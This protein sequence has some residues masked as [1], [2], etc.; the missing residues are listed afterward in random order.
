MT[1]TLCM[2]V[3]NHEDLLVR[4]WRSCQKH[5]PIDNAILSVS[6][7]AMED[8][9]VD[10]LLSKCTRSKLRNEVTILP[11]IQD[12][13]FIG[14]ARFAQ[15]DEACLD[16]S[17]GWIINMDD[18]DHVIYD[19][20]LNTI[21][22]HVGLWHAG[23]I[24]HCIEATSGRL[25]GDVF[26]RTT[27]AVTS[28]EEANYFRGAL[29]GIRKSVWRQIQH[30]VCR[31][32]PSDDWGMAY[33]AV[34][35]GTGVHFFKE[36]LQI[37]RVHAFYPDPRKTVTWPELLKKLQKWF[38]D[39]DRYWQN[40]RAKNEPYSFEGWRPE[41][42]ELGRRWWYGGYS[43]E[44]YHKATREVLRSVVQDLSC[45]SILD[46]GC[47]P[48]P[49]QPFFRGLDAT[50]LGVDN[51]KA[52][53]T[54]A[55]KVAKTLKFTWADAIDSPLPKAD[56][57]FA[58]RLLPHLPWNIA[59][60][61]IQRLFSAA[62]KAVVLTWP[63]LDRFPQRREHFIDGKVWSYPTQKDVVG[64][65][66][67]HRPSTITVNVTMDRD[68]KLVTFVIKKR[69]RRNTCTTSTTSVGSP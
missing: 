21:P 6:P 34:R 59:P 20:P 69:G 58:G 48:A 24:G 46:V 65:L 26:E 7:K 23:I 32:T 66:S 40:F 4:S 14:Y 50:Y 52:I 61:V 63:C 15:F 2:L 27:K 56:L 43:D 30:I 51:H 31:W 53:L 47:G 1:N 41:D 3:S 39:Q 55:G 28:P 54:A 33:H 44:V 45:E 67:P 60:A 35:L 62:R 64:L 19:V 10:H 36:P 16:G 18:D 17:D 37:Q 57:V 22:E 49:D 13:L 11:G 29:W 42:A 5:I 38:V 8:G 68:I 25:P 12:R 9:R